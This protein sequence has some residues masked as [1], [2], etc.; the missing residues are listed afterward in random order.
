MSKA[1]KKSTATKTTAVPPSVETAA[2]TIVIAKKEEKYT[3]ARAQWYTALREH[4]GQTIEAFVAACTKKPPSTPSSGKA[5]DPRG[6]LRWFVR[7]G[8]A[9]L[10]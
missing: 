3:G 4:E 10:S 8:V 5:E 2:P 7:N 6:W 9:T 1:T